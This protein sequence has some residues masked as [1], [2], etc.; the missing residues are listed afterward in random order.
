MVIGAFARHRQNEEFLQQR[1]RRFLE[2][3]E[4]THR[5]GW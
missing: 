2:T 3:M 5:D 1:D 4:A